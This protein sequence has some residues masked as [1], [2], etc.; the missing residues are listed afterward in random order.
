MPRPSQGTDLALLRSGRA[1]FADCGCAGLS[2]RALAEHAGVNLGMFHYHFK[3]KDAFVRVLLAALYEEMFADLELAAGDP[4]PWSA[5]RKALGVLARFARAHRKLLRRLIADAMNGEPLA[6]EFL[7]ENLPRH[8]GVVLGLVAAAQRAKLA[9]PMPAPQA[10]AF[11]AGAIAAPVLIGSALVEHGLA[12]P[13]LAA[14]FEEAVLSDAALDARID[15]A[16]AGIATP[17]QAS[18]GS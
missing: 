18:Q 7:R 4:A 2:L 11:L 3:T 16:L 17:A 14:A 13:A 10:I 15:L 12:P 9:K 6:R 8:V 5:L 1:L